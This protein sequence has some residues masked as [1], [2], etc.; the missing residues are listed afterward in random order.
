MLWPLTEIVLNDD[1][2]THDALQTQD[3][4]GVAGGGSLS[5]AWERL[6]G[7][8]VC[9]HASNVPALLTELGQVIDPLAHLNQQC[10]A[11][12]V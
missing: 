9:Q 7:L 6:V 4:D 5:G 11:A 2:N 3:L 12:T 8:D 10:M 1:R